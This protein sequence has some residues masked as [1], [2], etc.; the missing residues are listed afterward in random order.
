MD[1]LRGN[2]RW[3]FRI[4][5][6]SA[7]VCAAHAAREGPVKIDP[8]DE[9]FTGTTVRHLRIE[10]SQEDMAVLRKPLPRGRSAE[11]PAVSATV[12]EGDHVWTNVAVHLKGSY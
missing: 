12:R 9:L 4:I 5:V 2:V 3:F 6:A 10:I 8:S 7:C 11:R 1:T